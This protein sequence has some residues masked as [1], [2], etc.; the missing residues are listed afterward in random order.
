MVNAVKI[1]LDHGEQDDEVL[2][3]VLYQDSKLRRREDT[4]C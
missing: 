4:S 2:T 1:P 3:L